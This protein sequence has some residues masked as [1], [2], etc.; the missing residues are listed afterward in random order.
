MRYTCEGTGMDQTFPVTVFS[1][2]SLL[3]VVQCPTT[4]GHNLQPCLYNESVYCSISFDISMSCHGPKLA[5][6]RM[7]RKQVL[8]EAEASLVREILADGGT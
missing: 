1:I 7:L 2:S 6:E 4:S 8:T 5:K 3:Q